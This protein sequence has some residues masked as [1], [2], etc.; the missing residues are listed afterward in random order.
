LEKDAIGVGFCALDM[1]PSRSLFDLDIFD[2]MA[3]HVVVS[4][5]E[6]SSA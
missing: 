1:A 3:A 2:G 6:R 5:Q 4:T